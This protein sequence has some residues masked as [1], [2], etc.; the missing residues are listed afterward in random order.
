MVKINRRRISLRGLMRTADWQLV[1]GNLMTILMIFF[2]VLFYINH[3]K[4]GSE[5]EQILSRMQTEFG[6]IS[7]E[8]MVKR[9]KYRETENEVAEEIGDSEGLKKFTRVES[10]R[11]K[12]KIVFPDPVIFS[13]GSADLEPETMWIM[14]EI[15]AKLKRLPENKIIIEG[16]TDNIPVARGSRYADNWELS[17][18]R[19]LNIVHYLVDVEGMNP[20]RFMPI[21]FGANRPLFPNDTREQRAQNR[22]IEISIIKKG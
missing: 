15:A 22:R 21:G 18:A 7:N 9:A 2:M 14:N 16:H 1:H 19:S 12:I 3:L 20:E 8:S 11:S 17:L 4:K 5:Y 6:G 13:T 10:D